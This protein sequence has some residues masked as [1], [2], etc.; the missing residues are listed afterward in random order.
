MLLPAIGAVELFATDI[1]PMPMPAVLPPA[2]LPAGTAPI[3]TDKSYRIYPGDL[4]KVEVFDHP[5]L[6]IQLNI[7]TNGHITFPMIGDI[8]GIVGRTVEDLTVELKRRLE[9][10]WVP[11]AIV[12]ISFLQFGPRTAYVL[13][14]VKNPSAINL[15]PFATT[16]VMQAISQAGGFADGANRMGAHIVRSRHDGQGGKVIIPIPASDDLKE[17]KHDIPLEPEDIIVI[18]RLDR[19]F[20]L[21]QVKKPGA[22]DL[23]GTEDLTVSK[24]ISIAGGFERFG[25]Q[26]EVQVIR[27]GVTIKVVDVKAALAGGHVDDPKLQPGDTIFVPETRF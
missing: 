14:S 17:L 8:D 23:P 13:G 6:D 10:G 2:S 21:G 20:I 3:P 15:T 11:T 18:P 22:V 5:E 7:P 24:A 1:E 26:S 19:I 12:T 27:N 25:R 4:M 9:D 16:S